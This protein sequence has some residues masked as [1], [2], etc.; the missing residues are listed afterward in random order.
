MN[1]YAGGHDYSPEDIRRLARYFELLHV[2]YKQLESVGKIS[3]EGI[4]L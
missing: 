3:K 2:T 1:N 4:L